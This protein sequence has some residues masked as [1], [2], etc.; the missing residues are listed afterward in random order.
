[1]APQFFTTG[2]T[3]GVRAK[4]L[5]ELEEMGA[6]LE[7]DLRGRTWCVGDRFTV[8]DIYVYMLVGWQHYKPGLRIGG[9]AVEEHYARVGERPAIARARELDDLD[10]RLLRHHPELRGGR[11]VDA[12]VV[13]FSI[14]PRRNLRHNGRVRAR[15]HRAQA[16]EH[17]A[18]GLPRRLLRLALHVAAGP[19]GERVPAVLAVARDH[20]V[21]HL[22]RRRGAHR[23]ALRPDALDHL[24]VAA[25]RRG[26][27]ADG[28]H[29]HPARAAARPP[30]AG[31]R[32]RGVR[33]DGG[34][35][36]AG[37]GVRRRAAHRRHAGRRQRRVRRVRTR[38][39]PPRP[40]RCWYRRRTSTPPT[41]RRS[42]STT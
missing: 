39:S 16:P 8:A 9:D 6:V 11:P 26:V 41:P 15:V 31:A 25:V 17:M 2:D 22:G 10:E 21:R 18:T 33:A 19:N 23:P 24:G 14:A 38:S 30:A 36:V 42:R 37:A 40:R 1:M 20:D 5:E 28:V 34:C 3:A 27:R 35:H 7:A 13:E 4:G 32:A 12:P 29:R